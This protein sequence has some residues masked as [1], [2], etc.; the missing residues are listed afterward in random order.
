M[1]RPLN[2]ADVVFSLTRQWKE[3]HPFHAISGAR[4]DYFKDMGFGELLVKQCGTTH[5][6]SF[7]DLG[8][9]VL[10]SQV[11][12]MIKSGKQPGIGRGWP[13]VRSFGSPS[14]AT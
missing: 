3:D 7:K 9:T 12:H 4:F 6:G 14:A 1:L 10:V 11:N 2:S 5:T 13:A 8:M